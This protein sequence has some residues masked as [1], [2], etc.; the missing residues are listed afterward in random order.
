M[1]PERTLLWEFLSSEDF[2]VRRS[3]IAKFKAGIWKIVRDRRH[4]L[5]ADEA[6][7]IGIDWRR[8][9]KCVKDA[10][11]RMGIRK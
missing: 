4:A 9:A 2:L 7:I 10:L 8:P 11:S 6:A 5:D 3:G 1:Q